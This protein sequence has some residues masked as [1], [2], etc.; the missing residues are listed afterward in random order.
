MHHRPSMNPHAEAL[1]KRTFNFALRIVHFCRRLRKTWEGGE[2]ADQ[3][4][5]A[6]TRVGANYR[7][8]C[9]GRSHDD[10]VAKL[11]HVVEEADE[12]VYWLELIIAAKT[13]DDPDLAPILAEANE[14]LAIFNQSQLTARMNQAARRVAKNSQ[15]N[16]RQSKSKS[17]SKSPN[18]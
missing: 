7:A 8:A 9:R 3:I 11:G 17:K 13:I 6:G 5:R 14:L 10:F 12:S 4:F 2:F 15:S 16:N 18:S 1:K